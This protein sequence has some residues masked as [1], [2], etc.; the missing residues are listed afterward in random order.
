[1]TET[2]AVVW[3]T[4]SSLSERIGAEATHEILNRYFEAA[5]S[6]IEEFGGSVDK[7]IGDN[8]MGV[9]GAPVAHDNDPER[10]VRA[11]LAIHEAV[12]AIDVPGEG[13]LRLHIGIATGQ[14]VASGTGSASHRQYTV[15]GNSV[16]LAARLQSL[17][18]ADETLISEVVQRQT[19][20]R[21]KVAGLG[22]Q[23][24][25]GIERLV[26][27]WR[28]EGVADDPAE[29]GGAMFVGRRAELRQCQAILDAVAASGEG[30]VVLLRGAA[31]IGK[32]RLAGEV[33][34]MA[35]AAGFAVHRCLVLDFGSLSGQSAVP[36]LVAGRNR[37]L[38][39]H[40]GARGRDGRRREAGSLRACRA[41]VSQRP[42]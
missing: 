11:A 37:R 32:T 20:G 36:A 23:E 22:P 15:T 21:F 19:T 12:R 9:F 2:G 39:R 41:R 31:G 29:A 10:A 17:A 1:M 8:V 6:I 3:I 13:A 33:V 14:V 27:V 5:D 38:E 40:D 26:E 4:S 18:G 35:R 25:K 7:H 34:R 24:L 42:A 28:V 16:N 30:Q